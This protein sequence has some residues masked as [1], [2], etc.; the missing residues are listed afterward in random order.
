MNERQ[1]VGFDSL[2]QM[3]IDVPYS[4]L[5]RD[6]DYAWS[7]GQLAL[8]GDSNVVAAYDLTA[9]STLVAGYIE[10]V[11]MRGNL[12]PEHL[13]RLLLYF[14]PTH[15]HADT[16]Q[17]ENMRG[18]FRSVFGDEVLLDV[19][20]VPYFYYDGIVLEVDAFAGPTTHDRFEW[21]SI[22]A[23][24]DTLAEQIASINPAG[25]LAAH[26][27]VPESNLMSVAA[28]L[29][30]ARLVHDAGA[31]VSAGHR[32]SLVRGVLLSV[33]NGEVAERQS[34]V[35]NVNVTSR[36]A[37]G[38]G[39]IGA[40]CTDA[41]LGL[42]AQTE[43]IMDAIAATLAAEGVDFN[44]VVKSTTFYVGDSSEDDLHDNMSV[45]NRR[46]EKP[47][48]ASTGLP[49]FGFA[50]QRTLLSIDITYLADAPPGKEA[51]TSGY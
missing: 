35:R 8:D 26:W 3:R 16:E 37:D 24:I 12:G 50:D 30:K 6:G 38:A 48:P 40:R 47:G 17:V 46:Y 36:R 44:A 10:E 4:L 42:V 22:E 33:G 49:V 7:C 14:V 15:E 20:P 25:I 2:W 19:A 21:I 11:L 39:W 51:R 43:A 34:H 9:Q 23:P 31:V 1:F 45:R 28:G 5:V 29:E 41:S 27:F 18:V 32:T 13:K